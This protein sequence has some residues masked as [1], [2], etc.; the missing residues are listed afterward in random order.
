VRPEPAAVGSVA[1]SPLRLALLGAI[2]PNKGVHLAIDAVQALRAQGLP[3]ELTIAGQPGVS[4]VGYW[5]ACQSMIERAP[6]GFHVT[7]DFVPDVDLRARLLESDAVLLPYDSFEA[8][9]GVAI[10]AISSGRAII[11][12]CAGGLEELVQRSGAAIR[13]ESASAEAVRAAIKDAL[14]VGQSGLAALGAAGAAYAREYLDW[15]RVADRHVQLYRKLAR[16]P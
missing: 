5:R 10:D 9:S 16:S 1:D 2:R 15:Q 7:S 8:Q 11:A 4:D 13:I 6:I 3:I 12:T 14:A